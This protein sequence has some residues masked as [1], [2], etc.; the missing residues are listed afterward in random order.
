MLKNLL[1][2]EES[3]NENREEEAKPV[4]PVLKKSFIIWL[5]I[6]CLLAIAP[7]G[8]TLILTPVDRLD[9][10]IFESAD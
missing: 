3:E 4:P 8:N 10:E 9:Y 6:A 2:G 5:S 1:F 7:Y